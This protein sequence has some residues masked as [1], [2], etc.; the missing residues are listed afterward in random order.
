MR[1]F[2]KLI[3]GALLLSFML[4]LSAA[5]AR[6]SQEGI[7]AYISAQHKAVLE[8]WLKQKPDLRVATAEDLDADLLKTVTDMFPDRVASPFYV[9]GD[10]NNDGQKDFAIGLVVKNKPKDLALAVFNGPLGKTSAPAY[11]NEN[12][13]DR[14][15]LL[16]VSF[17]DRNR[18]VLQIGIGSDSRTVFLKP[19]GKGYYIWAGA[20]Q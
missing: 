11:Y 12:R 4:A 19:K 17:D 3:C 7:P 15:D 6:T 16:F 2:T 5:H 1:I 20:T 9:V 8:K 14:G 18:E 13:F 10:F